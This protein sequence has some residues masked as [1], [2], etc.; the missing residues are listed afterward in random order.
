MGQSGSSSGGGAGSKA[1]IVHVVFFGVKSEREA[2]KQ[3]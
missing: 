1:Y 2:T 3:E